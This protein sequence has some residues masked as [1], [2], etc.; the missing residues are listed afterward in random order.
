MTTIANHD[1][2]PAVSSR[3]CQSSQFLPMKPAM[4]GLGYRHPQLGSAHGGE[5]CAYTTKIISRI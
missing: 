1:K 3:S 4:Q 5:E 2:I